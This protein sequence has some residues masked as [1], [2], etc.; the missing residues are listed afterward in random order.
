MR[1]NVTDKNIVIVPQKV[2][3][4]VL[5]SVPRSTQQV[6]YFNVEDE[7]HFQYRGF[8]DDFGPPSILQLYS[9]TKML[10]E[11]ME[12][13]ETLLHFYVSQNPASKA[14]AALFI[15]AFRMFHLKVNA[16]EA[17]KPIKPMS[18][19]IKP[20]RDAST[21][22]STF[23]L[24][25]IDCLRGLQRAMSLG[26]F[27][28]ENF[29]PETWAKLEKIENGDMNW[30]IPGKLL[31]FASPYSQNILPG[32]YHVAIPSD[33]IPTFKDLGVNHIIRLNKQFY[34]REDFVKADF[35][36]TEL[37]FLDGSCPPPD[38]LKSFLEIIE[39]DDIV[40]L[41]CK[42]G[43]GRT[44]TLAG[45]YMIKHFEF[46]AREAIG[47][48][49]LC[50]PGSVI[51]PQQQYLVTYHSDLMPPKTEAKTSNETKSRSPRKNKI[52][53]PTRGLAPR[54]ND[55]QN[56][57][58]KR[59]DSAR[60]QIRKPFGDGSGEKLCVRATPINSLHPQPR[61]FNQKEA[62]KR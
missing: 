38:I 46:T 54:M 16:E 26:W 60:A 49:R 52:S 28:L 36:H 23:D 30:L 2:L 10:E 19:T 45:C 1:G 14:N 9:F 8:F 33:V 34:D 42:A 59:Q 32:G 4:S 15:T 55:N 50:R 40:A 47:W 6:L 51:G 31:A 48:I 3:F 21:L 17:F 7:P 58:S 24:T 25:V 35:K 56:L 11:F 53:S 39:T 41:H 43:L 5:R 13:N 27:S 57:K 20:F 62:P 44:G 12:K 29:D 37:Y 22:P 61:K 18:N